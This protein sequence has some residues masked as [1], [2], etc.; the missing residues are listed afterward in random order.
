VP[1]FYPSVPA[2]TPGSWW[3][4]LPAFVREDAR[5]P[6]GSFYVV[7]L[8]AAIEVLRSVCTAL[9]SLGPDKVTVYEPTADPAAR[10]G[11]L[12]HLV[13]LYPRTNLDALEDYIRN[14]LAECRRS[15]ARR[16]RGDLVRG[17]VDTLTQESI[18]GFAKTL[19]QGMGLAGSRAASLGA[20]PTGLTY[21]ELL[22]LGQLLHLDEHLLSGLLDVLIDEA[23]ATTRVERHREWVGRRML[24]RTFALDGEVVAREVC[25]FSA[26]H[27]VPTELV[28]WAA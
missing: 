21:G 18:A 11:A 3:E 17:R 26:E 28:E 10:T 1:I 4:A 8:L 22:Q 15:A 14:V 20:R 13:T 6:T 16:R 24:L 27:G 9:Y 12:S 23:Y 25:R 19:M 2:A 5:T 7:G